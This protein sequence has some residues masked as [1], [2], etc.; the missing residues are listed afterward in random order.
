M[1]PNDK[2]TDEMS[3]KIGDLVNGGERI[4]ADVLDCCKDVRREDRICAE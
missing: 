1:P 2:H 3:P 4:A